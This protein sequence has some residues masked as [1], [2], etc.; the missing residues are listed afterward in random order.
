MSTN[1]FTFVK[2]KSTQLKTWTKQQLARFKPE[3]YTIKGASIALVLLSFIFYLIYVSKVTLDAGDPWLLLFFI[4][5]ALIFIIASYVITWLSAKVMAIPK[6]YRL[7]LLVSSPLLFFAFGFEALYWLFAITM[8]SIFGAIVAVFKGGHFAS[9]SKVKKTTTLLGTGIVLVGGIALTYAFVVPGFDTESVVNAAALNR[10]SINNIDAISPAKKGEYS[11][12]AFTY[13]AGT[14]KHRSEFAEQVSLKTDTTDGTVFLDGWSGFNGWYREYFWGFD[15]TELPLNAYVWMP[16]GEGPFPLVLMVHGNHFMQD[17]SDDGYAYLGELLAS[18]GIIFASVDQ[19][20]INGSWSD[21]GGGLSKENDARGWLLLEHL[22]VW[23]EWNADSNSELF[24]KVDTNNLG[25]IGHSRGGEAVAHAALLNK[26]PLFYDDASYV[27]DYNFN[28]KALLAIAPVDGQYK[29]GKTYTALEDINYFTMHGSQDGDVTSFAGSQQYERV[30]FS[31]DSNFFKASLYVQN[32]N[33]G[34]F[35]STW[36]ENDTMSPTKLLNNQDL[37]SV[38]EQTTI[39]QVY[40]SAFFSATLLGQKQY[41]PLFIDA[42]KGKDW[43]PDT[44]YVSQFE[45]SQFYEL[46]S[47]DEDFNVLTSATGGTIEGK[48]LSVWREQAVQMSWREKGTRAVYLG[49]HKEKNDVEQQGTQEQGAEQHGT[50]QQSK[51]LSEEPELQQSREQAQE[52][53]P[54]QE[55]DYASYTILINQSLSDKLTEQSMNDLSFV[56][57]M[58]PSTESSNPKSRGKWVKNEVNSVS[59][60]KENTEEL[61]PSPNQEN[62]ESTEAKEVK[63]QKE[64]KVI[65]FTITFTDENGQSAAYPLSTF[66]ALQPRINVQIWKSQFIT[67]DSKSENIFQTFVYP[68]EDILSINPE[69]NLQ[70]LNKVTFTFNKTEKGVVIID[71]I[72]FMKNIE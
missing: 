18:K 13:G 54:Q 1:A 3:Y 52:P 14:D 63:E 17:F 65:D 28:I 35:N 44:I 32:A 7:A 8:F 66:S 4:C 69:L 34:Q 71:R 25:L 31:P 9:L 62:T 27:L 21:I 24:G 61:E 55:K 6:V 2:D 56:F 58:A 59:V 51:N 36:G 10:D 19:N 60:S 38:S 15:A 67:G 68:F 5:L 33:H 41:V 49:W 72:G 53:V 11:F 45:S 70:M 26:M 20:F 39:S 47:F 37:L 30:L 12:K 64:D 43:L 48:N 50:Q 46:A 23:H 40:T 42:R 22:R 57:S 16:E 29:P